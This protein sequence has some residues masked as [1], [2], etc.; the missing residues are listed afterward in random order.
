MEPKPD[1][2]EEKTAEAG[3]TNEVEPAPE[4]HIYDG[5]LV[6]LLHAR[7]N[8]CL[9]LVTELLRMHTLTD[10]VLL[11]V[12]FISF[13]LRPFCR[14]LLQFLRF[15]FL[16]SSILVYLQLSSVGIEIMFVENITPMQV[17]AVQLLSMVRKRFIIVLIY[18]S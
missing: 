10:R 5:K 17:N 13:C 3:G 9:G 18:Y 2:D 11:K 15:L 6:K 7:H 14:E 16:K 8:E 1:V 12:G 4:P